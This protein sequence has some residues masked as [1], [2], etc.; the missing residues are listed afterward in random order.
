MKKPLD[1]SVA[2][3]ILAAVSIAFITMWTYQPSTENEF[4]WDSIQYL[5]NHVYYL[6]SLNTDHI[7][8][9]FLTLDGANWH[10]LTWISWAIDYQIYG[11]LIPAGYH[12]TNNALHAINSVLIFITMLVVFALNKPN[13]RSFPFLA[14][15]NAIIAATLATFFF[16]IHPQHVESVAWVAERK[17]LLCQLFMLLSTLAYVRYA[18]CHEDAHR[19][20]FNITLGLFFLAALSKPMAVTFPA[21]LLLLDVYPLRRTAL[22]QPV[23]D[24][25]RQRSYSALLKEKLPFLLITVLLVLVTLFAQQAALSKVPVDLRILNAANSIIFYLYK[26]LIPITFVPHYPYYID[27]G[28]AITWKAF[29][30]MFGV[31]GLTIAGLIMW[32]R[33]RH[34]W[35]ISWLF[36]LITLSPVLGLIQVGQQGAADRYAYLPTLPVYFLIGAGLLAFLNRSNFFIQPLI[37]LTVIPILFLLTVQTRQQIQIWKDPLTLWSHIVE[38]YPENSKSQHNMGIV[39][40]NLRNYEKAAFHFGENLKI[41]PASAGSLYLRGLTYLHMHQNE[42]ALKDYMAL[43]T[44]LESKPST[45]LDWDCYY[46]NTGWLFAQ[47]GNID[48][49]EKFFRKV[50]LNSQLQPNVKIWLDQLEKDYSEDRFKNN[51]LPGFCKR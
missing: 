6:S 26:L 29:V 21:V 51:D 41:N 8:W 2:K 46:Y 11:G 3:I 42:D 25:I 18:S 10:P 24:C 1:W 44:I 4:V 16:A 36:Y 32:L 13:S 37:L 40:M 33:G 47:S 39:Y 48:N 45:I 28:Q 38:N 35:L 20:W 31:V 17:D 23:N 43:D 50:S 22:I 7:I 9:M 27:V 19:R 15:D 14:Q 12:L 5:R 34:E 30:P 49:A